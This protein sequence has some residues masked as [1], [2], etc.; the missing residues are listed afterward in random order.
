MFNFTANAQTTTCP[1]T[2]FQ[3]DEN[4][5]TYS[6]IRYVNENGL[7]EFNGRNFNSVMTLESP[8]LGPNT[9]GNTF[10]YPSSLSLVSKRIE[11]NMI[12]DD[13]NN[14]YIDFWSKSSDMKWQ[15][16]MISTVNYSLY[17]VSDPLYP[18]N[19]TTLSKNIRSGLSFHCSEG[20]LGEA[21]S[22][23][24][25]TMEVFRIINGNMGIGAANPLHKFVVQPDPDWVNTSVT[26]DHKDQNPFIQFNRT[27]GETITNCPDGGY[28]AYSWKIDVNHDWQSKGYL[29][30][31]AIKTAGS[32]GCPY[33]AST[34]NTIATFTRDGKLFL[35]DLIYTGSSL[36]EDLKLSVDGGI[37]SKE[38]IITLDDW[39][40]YVFEDDYELMD[41]NE[42]ESSIKANGH[43]PGIPSA[44]QVKK[45]GVAVGEMQKQMMAKIEELTLYVIQL[46][47]E[48]DVIKKMLNNQNLEK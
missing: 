8:G 26:I 2:E 14:S 41:L 40:D 18:Y 38:L 33:E 21:S 48:N 25:T 37:V 46:K 12:T 47:K 29:G 4:P 32:A 23:A 36:T 7:Y 44:E 17:D 22:G 31:M 24:L 43:L 3:K 20:T 13:Y 45:N 5:T 42:L 35:G 10:F 1:D 28:F 27:T 6:V 39:A 34:M 16:G 9:S 30:A 11:N 19:L 15:L